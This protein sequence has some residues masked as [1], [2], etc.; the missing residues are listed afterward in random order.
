M[1]LFEEDN[2][3]KHKETM[4]TLKKNNLEEYTINLLNQKHQIEETLKI[5]ESNL[6][7]S[8]Q[9]LKYYEKKFLQSET[10]YEHNYSQKRRILPTKQNI[11]AK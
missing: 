2:L 4:R 7:I 1:L 10:L 3:E 6:H 5:T 11:P 9:D 8:M